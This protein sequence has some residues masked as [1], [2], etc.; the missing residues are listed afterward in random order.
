MSGR[1]SRRRVPLL[2]VLVLVGALTPAGPALGVTKSQV[3]RACS[4]SAGAYDAYLSA[5]AEFQAAAEAY[6]VA[7]IEVENVLYR[8]ERAAET[9]EIRQTDMEVA[10]ERFQQQAVEAYM[11]GGSANPALFF[12]A[13]SLDEVITSTEFLSSAASDERDIAGDLAA[14][15]GELGVLQG[16]LVVLEQDLRVVEAQR[17]EAKD[18]QEQAM[19]AD[20]AA[21]EKLSGAMRHPPEAVSRSRWPGQPRPGV[22]VRAGCPRRRLPVSDVPFPGS[23]FTDSWGAPRSGGQGPQGHRHDGAI[24]GPLLCRRQRDRLYRQQRS[25]RPD[26]YGW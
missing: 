24:R 21:W 8:Q 13:S 19:L 1:F 4:T 26:R 22:A 23:S 17:L 11:N 16:Q 15:Q 20:Q 18:A 12:M 10:K 7:S 6:E 2:M 5:K 25:R 9:L 3:D 14:L